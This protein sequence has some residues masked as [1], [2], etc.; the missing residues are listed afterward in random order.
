MIRRF[1]V[2]ANR[3][4]EINADD[5]AADDEMELPEEVARCAGRYF[6]PEV[7]VGVREQAARSCNLPLWQPSAAFVFLRRNVSGNRR[8]MVWFPSV[9]LQAPFK[10]W[11]P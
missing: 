3:M 7:F 4:P 5:L 6:W 2:A 8:R 9:S 10:K 1:E 11:L